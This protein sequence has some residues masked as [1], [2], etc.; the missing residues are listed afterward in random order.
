MKIFTETFLQVLLKRKLDNIGFNS[1]FMF[2]QLFHTICLLEHRRRGKI[3]T[4]E[5]FCVFI[6]FLEK[7]FCFPFFTCLYK[8]HFVCF[9]FP[10]LFFFHFK[11]FIRISLAMSA[12][13]LNRSHLVPL[14][15]ARWSC[16][17]AGVRIRKLVDEQRV[18][19]ASF[20]IAVV[21]HPNS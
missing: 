7:Y 2:L 15:R 14:G 3:T 19:H 5:F 10:F 4:K 1:K 17:E 6:M 21:L 16:M 13:Y 9:C 12:E 8:I 18:L 11:N 20:G